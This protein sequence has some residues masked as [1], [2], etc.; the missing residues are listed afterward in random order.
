[1]KEMNLVG[2]DFYFFL[3]AETERHCVVYRRKA[4]SYGLIQP[5]VE[6]MEGSHGEGP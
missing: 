5:N 4:G 2:H 1:V 6:K 3:N